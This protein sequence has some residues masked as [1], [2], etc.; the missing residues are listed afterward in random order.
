MTKHIPKAKMFEVLV[1]N[2]QCMTS[3]VVFHTADAAVENFL[4]VTDM[5]IDRNADTDLVQT[6]LSIIYADLTTHDERYVIMLIGP[7]TNTMANTIS[8]VLK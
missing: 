7:V 3:C 1:I 4:S 2:N 8:K 5:Y 6:A